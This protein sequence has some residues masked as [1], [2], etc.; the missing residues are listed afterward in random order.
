MASTH[1]GLD[2]QD[3]AA[4]VMSMTGRVSGPLRTGDVMRT[5]EPRYDSS[6]LPGQ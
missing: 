4:F 3:S 5:I 6:H 1:G 2:Q